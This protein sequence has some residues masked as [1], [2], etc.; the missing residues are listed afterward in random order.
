MSIKFKGVLRP[1]L[2]CGDSRVKQE[3]RD[4]V[5]VRAIVA[6]HRKTGLLEHVAKARPSFLDVSA[7][8]DFNSIVSKVRSATESFESLPAAVRSRF[9]NDPGEL[10]S[11]LSNAENLTEAVKLGLVERPKPPAP[12]PGPQ[13]VVIVEE[14]EEESPPP[15][16]SK[17][18][19]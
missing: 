3:F 18:K 19:P 17:S 7:I 5:D 4:F 2:K 6:R 12:A 8:G 13:R 11:F 15:R 14:P 9:H 10:I 16:K 1:S